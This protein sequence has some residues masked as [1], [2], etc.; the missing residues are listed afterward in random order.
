MHSFGFGAQHQPLTQTSPG[1]PQFWSP[2]ATSPPL[3]LNVT[4]PQTLGVRDLAE[5]FAKR[6]NRPAAIIG[7][8]AETA[9]LSNAAK[10]HQLLGP[11]RISI[12]QMIDWTADWLMRGGQTLDK[13][14]H[15]EARD[16]KY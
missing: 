6:L 4:G 13:P 11:P 12:D 14:T 10:S 1:F 8:E 3:I 2:H 9:L 16:G 7:Q 15:F 5:K